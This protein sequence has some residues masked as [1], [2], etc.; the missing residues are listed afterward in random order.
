MIVI[1]DISQFKKQY[2]SLILSI[3]NFDGVHIGHQ[4]LLKKVVSIGKSLGIPSG[5]LTFYPHPLQVLPGKECPPFL[6]TLRE[7]AAIFDILGF[8]V[9]LCL[10][11]SKDISGKTPAEFVHDVL[12]KKLGAKTIVVGHDYSF[13]KNREGNKEFLEGAG[14]KYGFNVIEEGALKSAGDIVSSTLIRNLLYE[15]NVEQATICLGR[16]YSITGKVSIGDS[17]GRALQIRTAKLRAPVNKLIPKKGVYIARA[18]IN[19]KTFESVLNIGN[20][21]TFGD[22]YGVAIE[23]HIL[24]F[25]EDIYHKTLSVDFMKR[26]R[27]EKKFE[28]VSQLRKQIEKDI[29]TTQEYFKN[30]RKS[31]I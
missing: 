19:G 4:S 18:N 12:W 23:V 30:L 20:Q 7:K 3:G 9:L 10:R 8:D 2:D 22:N 14:K 31:A 27:D 6:S 24:N 5:V 21:P 17:K 1:K 15:G 11:F 16:E 26:L 28:N 29:G 13:G 25:V